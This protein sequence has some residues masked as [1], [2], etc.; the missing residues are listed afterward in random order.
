MLI[1]NSTANVEITE[2]YC[3][4]SLKLSSGYDSISTDLLRAA[5]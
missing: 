2:V 5:C 1:I 3:K 4:Q